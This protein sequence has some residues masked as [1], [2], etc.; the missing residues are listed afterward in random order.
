MGRLIQL[1]GYPALSTSARFVVQDVRRS[2]G[3]SVDL[4]A[5]VSDDLTPFD[6]VGFEQGRKFFGGAALSIAAFGADLFL[7]LR[8][9]QDFVYLGVEARDDG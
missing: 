2:E 1:Y 7:H 6:D 3:Q 4:C 5:G 8:H 9:L